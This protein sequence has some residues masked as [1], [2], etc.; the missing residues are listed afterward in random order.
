MMWFEHMG[1]NRALTAAY[2]L[3]TALV[4][5]SWRSSLTGI[6]ATVRRLRSRGASVRVAPASREWLR[7][8]EADCAKHDNHR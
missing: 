3:G 4:A 2:W 8:H 7:E 6:T 5:Q 1:A